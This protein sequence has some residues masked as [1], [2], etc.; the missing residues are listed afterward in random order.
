MPNLYAEFP[1]ENLIWFSR[2]FGFIARQI[3]RIWEAAGQPATR[4]PFVLG[5]QWPLVVVVGGVEQAA[6]LVW[7]LW[8]P[9]ASHVAGEKRRRWL[10]WLQPLGVMAP[11]PHYYAPSCV[12]S[13]DTVRPRPRVGAGKGVH[14]DDGTR[15]GCLPVA[16]L[17]LLSFSFAA[18]WLGSVTLFASLSTASKCHRCFAF[19]TLICCNQLT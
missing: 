1:I 2:N 10:W 5:S 19:I 15:T 3:L 16:P 8:W 6:E 11:Q 7:W 18:A 13:G 12:H 17:E 9:L 4:R 14:D